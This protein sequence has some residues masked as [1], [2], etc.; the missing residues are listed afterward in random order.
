VFFL[1]PSL[2]TCS[3]AL[4]FNLSVFTRNNNNPLK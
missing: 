1:F 2:A 4:S 3:P